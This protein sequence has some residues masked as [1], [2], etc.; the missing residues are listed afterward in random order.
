MDCDIRANYTLP[1]INNNKLN[2]KLD[3]LEKQG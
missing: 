3:K 1:T 2:P